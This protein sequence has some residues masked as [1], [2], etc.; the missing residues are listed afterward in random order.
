MIDDGVRPPT[1]LKAYITTIFIFPCEEL[2]HKSNRICLNYE[3]PE[4]ID[5]HDDLDVFYDWHLWDPSDSVDDNIYIRVAQQK[6]D[7]NV[8]LQRI[9]VIS[10]VSPARSIWDPR[11]VGLLSDDRL[12]EGKQSLGSE[13]F[14]CPQILM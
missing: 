2:L 13:D 9:D 6:F 5:E 4:E 1:V 10:L 14:S 8:V 11:V 12:L 3:F 7:G